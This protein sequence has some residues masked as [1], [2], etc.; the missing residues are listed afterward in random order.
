MAGAEEN[1][2]NFGS[3]LSS[4]F[5]EAK[6]RGRLRVKEKKKETI[7]L[8]LTGRYNNTSNMSV[9][10]HSKYRQRASKI[11]TCYQDDSF[12]PNNSD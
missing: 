7:C 4:M 10:P 3:A 11:W 2:V 12:G 8:M 5:P 9:G 6:Q 1:T